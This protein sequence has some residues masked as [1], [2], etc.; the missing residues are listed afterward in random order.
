M[1][2]QSRSTDAQYHIN[3]DSGDHVSLVLTFIF[4]PE[5]RYLCCYNLNFCHY[6]IK[7]IQ[8]DLT[9]SLRDSA[10][11]SIFSVSKFAVGSSSVKIPQCKEKASAKASLIIIDANTYM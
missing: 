1:F 6:I 2:V 3:S 5:Y 9:Y 4:I 11:L 8:Y 10:R 7:H